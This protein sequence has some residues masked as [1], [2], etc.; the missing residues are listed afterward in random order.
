V[1][2]SA[3]GNGSFEG[4]TRGRA[5]AAAQAGGGDVLPGDGFD[6][7]Q[8]KAGAFEMRMFL[9]GLNTKQAGS[10]TDVAERFESGEIKLVSEGLEVDAREPGHRAEKLF[11]PGRVCVEFLENILC[12]VLHFVLRLAGS[13]RL[14]RSFQNLKSRALSMRECPRYNAGCF[15]HEKA[16]CRMAVGFGSDKG[17]RGLWP[18]AISRA[19]SLCIRRLSWWQISQPQRDPSQSTDVSWNRSTVA[20]AKLQAF[21]ESLPKILVGSLSAAAIMLKKYGR[22]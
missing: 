15:D 3:L 20:R 11:Q 12:S 18:G 17:M 4:I 13:Q 5:H 10:A 21:A 7:R 14:S 19:S 2:T 8:V 1:T 16:V 22:P 9:R 6:R